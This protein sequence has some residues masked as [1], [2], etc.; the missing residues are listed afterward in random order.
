MTSVRDAGALDTYCIH[1][2]VGSVHSRGGSME[3]TI[4]P[5]WPPAAVP[6]LA[7][8]SAPSKPTKRGSSCLSRLAGGAQAGGS[9]MV[10]LRVRRVGCLDGR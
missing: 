6:G 3:F 4:S 10:A 2:P 7:A 9:A 1:V 8:A 5:S